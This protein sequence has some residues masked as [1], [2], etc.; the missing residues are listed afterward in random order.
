MEK[1]NKIK[2]GILGFGEIGKAMAEFYSSPGS[3]QLVIKD[4]NR[5]DGLSGVQV[6]HVCIP[7]SEKFVQIVEGEIKR[8]KPALT[9]IHSTVAPGTTKEIG[10]MTVHSPVRG[11]HPNLYLGIKTFVKYIGADN[12]K[13]AELA[14]SHLE[15]LGIKTKIFSPSTTTE[16]GK[17][18]DTSYYGLCIAW[19]GEMDKICKQFGIDFKEAV[20]EFNETYNEGYEKL[21]KNNVL[22]PVLFPPENGIGGHCVIP[23]AEIIQKYFKSEAINLI[24]NYKPKK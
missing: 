22:R 19:H 6:L 2:V 12:E 5:D 18:L 8:S 3:P 10:G 20:T 14:K 13:A 1:I 9:I 7:W 4:L 21:G 11:V 15:G 17:L 24:L 23:N 16:I